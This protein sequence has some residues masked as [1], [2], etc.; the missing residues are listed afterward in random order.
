MYRLQLP[1]EQ[2]KQWD[3]T[4]LPPTGPF[5]FQE[6]PLARRLLQTGMP[7]HTRPKFREG[8]PNFVPTYG[9]VRPARRLL[10][11]MCQVKPGDNGA[12]MS[13]EGRTQISFGIRSY[14]NYCNIH[15][16]SLFC[17]FYHMTSEPG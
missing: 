1:A 17:G 5:F 8:F 7:I 16:L 11:E 14:K 4:F 13:S 9:P 2:R 10:S 12:S 15:P 3:P 6:E